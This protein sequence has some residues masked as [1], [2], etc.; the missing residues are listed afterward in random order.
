MFVTWDSAAP[1]FFGDAFEAM[2]IPKKYPAY[3]A[4][5]QRLLERPAVKKVMAEKAAMMA[6]GH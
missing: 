1:Y 4:W 2:E 6:K 5:K 3:W